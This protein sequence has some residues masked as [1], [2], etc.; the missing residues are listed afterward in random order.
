[1]AKNNAQIP[2]QECP[3]HLLSV[4]RIAKEQALPLYDVRKNKTPSECQSEYKKVFLT[5]ENHLLYN[6]INIAFSVKDNFV[7]RIYTGGRQ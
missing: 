1:M 7:K 5:Q 3:L 4:L 6:I 2:A